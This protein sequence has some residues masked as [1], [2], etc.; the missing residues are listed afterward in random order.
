MSKL[1]LIAVGNLGY[2][3]TIKEHNGNKFVS[4]SIAVNENYTDAAGQKHE[5]TD[6]INCTSRHLKIQQH[7]KKGDKVQVIGELRTKVFRDREGNNRVSLNI[8]VWQLDFVY[9]PNRN[10]EEPTPNSQPAEAD[11]NGNA[12]NNDDLPF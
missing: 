1:T 4:F 2:D 3:A 11:S 6:W 7:L 9:S 10:N 8:N 5:R 12:D